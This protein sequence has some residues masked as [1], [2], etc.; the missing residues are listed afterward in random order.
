M[1]IPQPPI[2]RRRKCRRAE[3]PFSHPFP[4]DGTKKTNM[5]NSIPVATA[6]T[7]VAL[8]FAVI[9][10]WLGRRTWIAGLSVAVILGYVA[11]VLHGPAVVWI[12]LFAGACLAYDRARAH[13]SPKIRAAGVALASAGILVLA[14]ALGLHSLPGFHN[15]L[16]L[17]GVVLSAGAAPYTLYLNFDK[18][19]VGICILGICYRG[20][21]GPPADW[22]RAF[23]RAAP[24]VA[25]NTLIVA[26]CAMALGYLLW[27]PKW[28]PV[29][30][31]WGLA[32]L[33]FTCLS[34][35]ALF[36]GFIQRELALALRGQRYGGGL[37]IAA[38]ALLFGAAH[39][40]GGLSYVALATAAGLGYAIV[41]HRTQSVEMS[42]LAHFALNA[43]HF[44]LFTYPRVG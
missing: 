11:N 8:L 4:S 2:L 28:T 15:F 27:Q 30:W 9:G 20:L 19:L 23:R 44:L 3:R 21:L 31:L 16:A 12:V 42:M 43:T 5:L 25:G 33:F 37:A 1:R 36:R 13:A 22:N 29:F 38:S 26:L 14:L 10:L 40:A 41:Y 7:Y 6:A 34:E 18:T 32:N 24:L 35:E 17:D 39:F